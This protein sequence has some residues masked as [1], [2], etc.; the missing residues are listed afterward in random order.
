MT[1]V[2]EYVATAGLNYPSMKDGKERRVEIG[3]LVLDMA[4]TSLK[5]ELR[6]GNV[7]PVGSDEE[8]A[9][10]DDQKEGSE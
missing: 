7:K 4:P 6:A 5:E 8:D 10:Q 3:E 9:T 1:E 2:Q